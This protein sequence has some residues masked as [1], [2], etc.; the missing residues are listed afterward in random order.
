MSVFNEYFKN[1]K[2]LPAKP[3]QQFTLKHKVTA[4]AINMLEILKHSSLTEPLQSKLRNGHPIPS[5]IAMP[6]P[7]DGAFAGLSGYFTIDYCK[8]L[9]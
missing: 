6:Q 8:Y 7:P 5:L 2:I 9:A 3:E 1:I 4:Q